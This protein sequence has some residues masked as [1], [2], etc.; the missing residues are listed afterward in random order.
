LV[1]AV[2]VAASGVYADVFDRAEAVYLVLAL[3]AAAM[4]PGRHRR[5]KVWDAPARDRRSS[6]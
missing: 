3:M 1:L 6:W 4:L 5:S 2:A